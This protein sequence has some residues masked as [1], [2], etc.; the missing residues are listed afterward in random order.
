MHDTQLELP[1]EHLARGY[2]ER[3]SACGREFPQEG[4]RFQRVRGLDAQYYCTQVCA[5]SRYV[6]PGIDVC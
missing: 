3:C 4:G 1:L 6:Q 2:H 5:S